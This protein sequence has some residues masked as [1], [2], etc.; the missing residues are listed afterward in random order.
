[1][2]RLHYAN[3]LSLNPEL[4]HCCVDVSLISLR[5]ST[6]FNRISV[7]TSSY[8]QSQSLKQISP[9][10]LQFAKLLF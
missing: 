10:T 7:R 9:I 8:R 6:S 2:C 5:T 3:P 1:M 4:G